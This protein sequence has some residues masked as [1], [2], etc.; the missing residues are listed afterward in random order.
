[1]EHKVG[2]VKHQTHHHPPP[3]CL[4][5]QLGCSVGRCCGVARS[6][7]T[8]T[9]RNLSPGLGLRKVN[10][11]SGQVRPRDL[12]IHKDPFASKSS[13]GFTWVVLAGSGGW[14]W[15]QGEAETVGR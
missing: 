5:Q 7:Q 14:S 2:D 6:A 13:L 15:G 10:P 11:N 9:L 12:I 8:K 1:M 4:A 3:S